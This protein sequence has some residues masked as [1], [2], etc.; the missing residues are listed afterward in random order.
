MLSPSEQWD[1]FVGSAEIGPITYI[2]STKP[3]RLAAAVTFW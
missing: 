3:H 1:I 2:P